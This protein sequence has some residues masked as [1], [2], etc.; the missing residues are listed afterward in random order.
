MERAL[1]AIIIVLGTVLSLVVRCVALA[2]TANKFYINFIG[3]DSHVGESGVTSTMIIQNMA[4]NDTFVWN[5][6]FSFNGTEP[7]GISG[8]LGGGTASNIQAYQDAISDQGSTTSQYIQFG[9]DDVGDDWDVWI[10]YIDQ[11]NA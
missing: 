2:S 10:T 9:I 1:R 11:N 7:T 4:V 8:T 6:K 5:D 3:W